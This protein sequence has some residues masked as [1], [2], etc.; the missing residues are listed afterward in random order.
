MTVAIPTEMDTMTMWSMARLRTS[1]QS[2]LRNVQKLDHQLTLV[3]MRDAFRASP[4][5]A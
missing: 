1:R 3:V 5:P 4:G 2:N